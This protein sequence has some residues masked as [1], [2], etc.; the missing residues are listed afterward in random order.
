[1]TM[2]SIVSS[3]KSHKELGN[4]GFRQLAGYIFG[5]N[6]TGQKIAM[7]TPVHMDINDTLSSMS[8]V[9]PAEYNPDNLPRPKDASIKITTVPEEHVAVLSFGGF[10][11]DE[12]I[13]N[14]AEKLESLLKN[15]GISHDGNFRY[16][17]YNPPYQLF[18]RK[19]EI[20]VRVRWAEKATSTTPGI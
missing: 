14:N 18:G 15:N 7:T 6:D 5:G 2:A 12:M 9:M 19:N 17:G 11:S 1:A 20:I 13:K 4:S 16:L 8:F 10:A 3:A